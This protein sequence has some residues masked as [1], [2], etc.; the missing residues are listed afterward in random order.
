MK[1]SKFVGFPLSIIMWVLLAVSVGFCWAYFGEVH[2]KNKSFSGSDKQIIDNADTASLTASILSSIALVS[3]TI[4][5]FSYTLQF[6][7]MGPI[8]ASLFFIE[9]IL[10]AVST[11]VLW[12]IS[13]PEQV[14]D[15]YLLTGAITSTV[16]LFLFTI[17]FGME[18]YPFFQEKMILAEGK[19]K[20]SVK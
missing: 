15:N 12:L 2:G 13:N 17:Y 10:I 8:S 1:G 4:Q 14:K 7:K 16:A 11:T 9:W 3:L 19:K 20:K 6:R 18:I 5:M